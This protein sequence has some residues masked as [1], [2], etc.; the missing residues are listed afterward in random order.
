M[1]PVAGLLALG[2]AVLLIAGCSSP[3]PRSNSNRRTFTSTSVAS[4]SADPS[5]SA[6]ATETASRHTAIP[7]SPTPAGTT[8]PAA[9]PSRGASTSTP[10]TG[11]RSAAA[12]PKPPRHTSG[13]AVET[14]FAPPAREP[15]RVVNKPHGG[16]SS[17]TVLAGPTLQNDY[18]R[19]WG[20]IETEPP[21]P[22]RQCAEVSNSG[23][24]LPVRLTL[25]IVNS[26]STS[27][28]NKFSLW[29]PS[30]ADFS[31]SLTPVWDCYLGSTFTLTQPASC[32]SGVTL[33]AA[34]A[35]RPTACLLGIQT[36]AAAGTDAEAA[37]RYNLQ[38]TCTGKQVSPCDQAAVVAPSPSHPVVV[39]WTH[40]VKLQ[41]CFAAVPTIADCPARHTVP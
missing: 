31:N 25:T 38:V 3:A 39:S 18:P 26:G 16:A 17:V 30:S 37:L 14:G 19:T 35:G 24:P 32:R 12:T 20:F 9:S 1:A 8:T 29:D 41:A 10:P 40:Q 28:A 34:S 13:P 23:T 27:D 33:P 6:A 21:D 4:L 22:A 11:R 36:S 2:V 5:S 15:S 7:L